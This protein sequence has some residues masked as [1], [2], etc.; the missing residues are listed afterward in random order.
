MGAVERIAQE[1]KTKLRPQ[2]RLYFACENFDLTFTMEEV[3]YVLKSYQEGVSMLEVT[4]K[5]QRNQVEIAILL[6]DLAERGK[7]EPRPSGIF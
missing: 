1:T 5:L 4:E 6:M 2:Q 3:D 7:I